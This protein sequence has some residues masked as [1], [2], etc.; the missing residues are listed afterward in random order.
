[1]TTLS[2]DGVIDALGGTVKTARLFK[3]APSAVSNWRRRGIPRALHYSMA[4]VCQKQGIAWEP[5]MVA[6]EGNAA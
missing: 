4:Q 6:N 2:D 5:P 1:M 3:V